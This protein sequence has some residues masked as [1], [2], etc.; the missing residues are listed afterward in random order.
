MSHTKPL[1]AVTIVFH[2]DVSKV[3]KVVAG[4]VHTGLIRV[5]GYFYIVRLASLTVS[6]GPGIIVKMDTALLQVSALPYSDEKMNATECK[7]DLPPAKAL[8][9]ASAPKL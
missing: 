5:V 2:R 6:T 8:Y 9:C 4:F 1:F 7:I 3:I